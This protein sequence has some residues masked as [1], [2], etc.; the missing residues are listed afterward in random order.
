M[1]A[2][3]DQPF[4][5]RSHTP[6]K[7]IGRTLAIALALAHLTASL[8]AC[9][10]DGREGQPCR[11][12]SPSMGERA[13]AQVYTGAGSTAGYVCDEGLFCDSTRGG[14]VCRRPQREGGSCAD[15]SQCVAGL[16]CDRVH[17]P[18][19]CR[20]PSTRAGD[21][22]QSPEHCAHLLFCIEQRCAPARGAGQRCADGIACAEGLA[23]IDGQCSTGRAAGAPCDGVARCQSGLV[24]LANRCVR[25]HGERE[26]CTPDTDPCVDELFCVNHRCQRG[27]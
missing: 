23:C 4:D 15:D 1:W 2:S 18:P 8:A 19:R 26:P 27:E 14:R 13:F 16:L 11:Y 5:Q 9:K 17:A 7:R 25:G 20:A 12:R 22:C 21:P 6:S 24:C 10:R 3:T